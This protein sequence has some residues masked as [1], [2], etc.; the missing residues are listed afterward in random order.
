MSEHY[1]NLRSQKMHCAHHLQS[2]SMLGRF[3]N[4]AMTL[5]D[6]TANLK[7]GIYPE[8]QTQFKN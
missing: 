7:L 5:I 1:I 6:N 2:R 8:F 3:N 4:A